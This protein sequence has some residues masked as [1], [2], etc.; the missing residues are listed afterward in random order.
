MA[1]LYSGSGSVNFFC[2]LQIL[3]LATLTSC[4]TLFLYRMLRPF[5][6]KIIILKVSSETPLIPHCMTN[7]LNKDVRAPCT[8]KSRHHIIKP[9]SCQ[10]ATRRQEGIFILSH[11]T[12]GV[13]RLH[14]KNRLSLILYKGVVEFCL[15]NQATHI[16]SLL[17][18]LVYRYS[19]IYWLYLALP[20]ASKAV[21]HR[22]TP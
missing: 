4:P 6:S 13:L 21:H 12:T 2:F 19:I 9:G 17:S 22:L 15:G 7:K 20:V 11:L 5:W 1:F 8:S 3:F 18:V 10:G 16:T 14:Q